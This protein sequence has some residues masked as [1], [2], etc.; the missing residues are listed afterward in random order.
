VATEPAAPKATVYG[1]GDAFLSGYVLPFEIAS[2]VL[3]VALI[4]AVVVS[5]K[6]VKA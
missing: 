4:G 1:I 6:E 5:R 3:L 2:L